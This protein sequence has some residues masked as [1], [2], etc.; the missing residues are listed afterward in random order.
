MTKSCLICSSVVFGDFE[1]CSDN[2]RSAKL[3]QERELARI[4]EKY[5]GTDYVVEMLPARDILP[6]ERG[7]VE[8]RVASR[9]SDYA[10]A[11]SH[12]IMLPQSVNHVVY[13]IGSV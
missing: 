7:P 13:N 8:I 6:G 1:F 9:Q 12:F 10:F 11:E 2:C 5:K 3:F 4:H